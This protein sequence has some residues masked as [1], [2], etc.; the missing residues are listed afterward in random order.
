VKPK[1]AQVFV[2]GYYAGVVDD[3]DGAFQRLHVRPGDHEIIVYL[4]GFHSLKQSLHVGR[5]QDVDIR[6]RLQPL[7]AG[8]QTEPPPQ[9]VARPEPQAQ[10]EPSERPRPLPRQRPV[11]Q[12]PPAA[13]PQ[14][15]AVAESGEAFGSLVIRV[16]PSGA[17]VLVDGERWQGPAGSERLVVQVSA[18]PHR[19]EIRKEGFVPFTTTIN[20]RKGQTAP[21]NV[22]LPK[23]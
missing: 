22:S 9:P 15:E 11:E 17:D 2:D 19:V 12:A 23:E 4:Q 13:P 3:F 7:A 20:V 18:G 14:D 5:N 16:Q 8:E 10:P 1:D 6:D 21:L